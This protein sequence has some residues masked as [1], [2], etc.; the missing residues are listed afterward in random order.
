[1]TTYVI[2]KLLKLFWKVY[3]EFAQILLKV[4]IA[5]FLLDKLFH[6]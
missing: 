4:M 5:Q 3:S 6:Q 2:E 1:M